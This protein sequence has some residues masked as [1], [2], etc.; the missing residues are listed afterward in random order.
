M[1]HLRSDKN[2]SPN[3]PQAANSQIEESYRLSIMERCHLF[4]KSLELDP[5][6]PQLDLVAHGLLSDPGDLDCAG[7]SAIAGLDAS[8]AETRLGKVGDGSLSS[9]PSR[10][11]AAGGRSARREGAEKD[12]DRPEPAKDCV[13]PATA[14]QYAVG[15]GTAEEDEQDR[16]NHIL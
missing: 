16:K 6:V 1:Y 12:D 5:P 8:E 4:G 3:F 14:R 15:S 13:R 11:D 2:G 7:T 9:L 10:G